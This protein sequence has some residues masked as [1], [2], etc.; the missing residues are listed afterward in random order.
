MFTLLLASVAGIWR[1]HLKLRARVLAEAR[2]PVTK[3]AT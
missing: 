3:S 2:G 1:Y